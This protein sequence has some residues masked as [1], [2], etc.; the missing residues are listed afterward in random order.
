MFLIF[1]ESEECSIYDRSCASHK[2]FSLADGLY[3]FGF[4]RS[5][6]EKK[7]FNE[8]TKKIKV[9]D[10]NQFILAIHLNKQI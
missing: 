6:T 1:N 2:H 5:H 8:F 4:H 3:V 10:C 9:S 7:L